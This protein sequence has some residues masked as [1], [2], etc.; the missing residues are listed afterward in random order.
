M[1]TTLLALSFA[2]GI[3][4]VCCQSAGA[5][6]AGGAAIQAAATTGSTIEQVQYRQHRGRHGIT[7]CYREFIFG[8]YVC[9]TYRYW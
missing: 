7:K 2:A 5:V 3:G 1:R 4:F 6:P 8:R 9:R